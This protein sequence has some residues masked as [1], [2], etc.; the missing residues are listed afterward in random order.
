[1]P[2]DSGEP[3]SVDLGAILEGLIE[4]GVDFILEGNII[5]GNNIIDL[6]E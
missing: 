2:T 5:Y 3:T 4:A 1:M 6:I